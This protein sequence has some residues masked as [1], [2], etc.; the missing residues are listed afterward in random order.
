MSPRR[1]DRWGSTPECRQLA[2]GAIFARTRSL[3]QG[4]L[5]SGCP[6]A[7]W[8]VQPGPVLPT[9]KDDRNIQGGDADEGQI[10]SSRTSANRH[11][12]DRGSRSRSADRVCVTPAL[13]TADPTPTMQLH[14]ATP[15]G[16][17]HPTPRRRTGR[18]SS[19][20][21]P[22]E[23]NTWRFGPRAIAGRSQ[24]HEDAVGAYQRQTR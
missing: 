6:T 19:S 23:R 2:G 16:G 4:C 9:P 12:A 1:V 7:S 24:P 14:P 10:V 22:S 8:C 18:H 3:P 13:P 5:G 11:N 15:G 17:R 20:G 21:G